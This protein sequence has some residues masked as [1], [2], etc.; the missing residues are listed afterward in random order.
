VRS[1]TPKPGGT[2]YALARICQ[3]SRKACLSLP[4]SVSAVC[5]RYDAPLPHQH[6][7]RPKSASRPQCPP[8]NPAGNLV[9]TTAPGFVVNALRTRSREPLRST[10]RRLGFATN[11]CLGILATG[12]WWACSGLKSCCLQDPLGCSTTPGLLL[13]RDVLG[14]YP[15]QVSIALR[16]KSTACEACLAPPFQQSINRINKAHLLPQGQHTISALSP[17][18][19]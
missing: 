7:P 9:P 10:A 8:P 16:L 1:R 3:R 14:V 6:S 11:S 4:L 2:I 13:G 5:R 19:L 15:H 17:L 18:R 12:S